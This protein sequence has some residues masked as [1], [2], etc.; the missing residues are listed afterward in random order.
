M[1]IKMLSQYIFGLEFRV[2]V[3]A[4]NSYFFREFNRNLVTKQA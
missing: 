4:K 1:L 2:K 3:N